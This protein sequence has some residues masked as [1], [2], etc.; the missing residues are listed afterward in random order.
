M[1]KVDREKEKYAARELERDRMM[2]KKNEKEI[3][4]MGASSA[5]RRN[6]QRKWIRDTVR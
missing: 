5:R 2:N 1:R 3:E 4:R 6:L